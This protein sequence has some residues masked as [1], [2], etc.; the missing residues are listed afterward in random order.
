MTFGDL[1][2]HFHINVIYAHVDFIKAHPEELRA[3]L[4]AILD[5]VA[6]VRAHRAETVAIAADE[7]GLSPALSGKLYDMLMPMYNDTGRF[8]P[9]ALATLAQAMVQMGELSAPPDMYK[10]LTEA[11]LPPA[12]HPG[13]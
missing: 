11:Y 12:P 10:L 2:A 8:N 1:V 7:L 13:Q 4:A 3:F 9:A 6:Y 5:S